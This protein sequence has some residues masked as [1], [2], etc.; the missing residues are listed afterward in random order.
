MQ[1]PASRRF[2][3]QPNVPPLVQ[4]QRVV[5]VVVVVAAAAA[6]VSAG[7]FQSPRQIE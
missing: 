7:A 2:Q 4:T 3:I 5:V 6:R 1:Q